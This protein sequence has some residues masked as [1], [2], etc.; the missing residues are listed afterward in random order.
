LYGAGYYRENTSPYGG[1]GSATKTDLSRAWEG[2]GGLDLNLRKHWGIRLVQFDY[3]S[4]HFFSGSGAPSQSSYRVSVGVV[5]R[6]G[7]R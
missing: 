6:F 5:Y 3:G 7:E 4:T 1:F 2:G